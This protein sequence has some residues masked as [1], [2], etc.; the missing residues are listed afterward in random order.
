MGFP[1]LHIYKG[2]LILKYTYFSFR[3]IFEN[4][5]SPA[6]IGNVSCPAEIISLQSS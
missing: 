1:T 5:T 6:S 2:L 4:S 3:L